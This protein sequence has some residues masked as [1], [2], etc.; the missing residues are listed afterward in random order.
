LWHWR[1]TTREILKNVRGAGVM[2][3]FDVQ[4]ADWREALRDRAFRRGLVLLPA[5]ERVLRFYPRYDTE[6]SAI[7]EALMILRL[8][9]EDL[10]GG[11]VASE[12]ATTVEIR[13]GT[14]AI[15]LDTLEVVELMPV[16]FDTH[17]L[18]VR[19]GTGA[20]RRD[21]EISTGCVARRA[22]TA[23]AVSPRN[24][25]NNCV[26]CSSIGI[27]LRDRVSSRFVAYALGSPLEDHDE[28]GI[29]ADP[30]FGENNTFY[31]QAMATVSDCE[32]RHRA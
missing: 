3:A 18:M 25:R 27:A 15:P 20:L 14:L 26:E 30:H 22:P 32:K 21:G 8:A 23:A 2:L 31:L 28:E 17:K 7:D 12:P 4:R 24:A 1:A 11:R 16:A 5:G 10:V 9:L 19:R 29:H 13:V 6:P